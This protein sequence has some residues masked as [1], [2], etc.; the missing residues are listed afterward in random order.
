MNCITIYQ[1]WAMM[2]ATGDKTIETRTHGGFYKL[3]GQRIGIHAGKHDIESAEDLLAEDFERHPEYAQYRGRAK[4][5]FGVILATAFVADHR[6]LVRADGKA[7]QCSIEQGLWGLV[8]ADV[9]QI[10][11]PFKINGQRGIWT[12][13]LEGKA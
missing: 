13:E 2:I 6:R 11:P 5:L 12:A 4:E 3:K 9:K 7:A 1:P 10:H 8:L